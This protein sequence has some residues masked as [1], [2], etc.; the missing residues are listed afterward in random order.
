MAPRA[1]VPPHYYRLKAVDDIKTLGNVIHNF[2]IIY[3][4]LKSV[5]TFNK[6]F[7]QKPKLLSTITV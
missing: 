3:A 6:L 1:Q 2:V 5:S 7:L 4:S